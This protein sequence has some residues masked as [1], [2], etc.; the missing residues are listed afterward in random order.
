MASLSALSALPVIVKA[1]FGVKALCFASLISDVLTVDLLVSFTNVAIFLSSGLKEVLHGHAVCVAH[2]NVRES[3]TNLSRRSSKKHCTI[4]HV[5][6]P[7][8]ALMEFMSSTPPPLTLTGYVAQ[9]RSK[10][11][12]SLKCV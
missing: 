12:M 9:V 4:H 10:C 6:F 11:D 5:P 7:V 3:D 2:S 1:Q 8:S